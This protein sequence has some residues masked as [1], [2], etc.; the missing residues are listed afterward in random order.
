M[1]RWVLVTRPIGPTRLT[2]DVVTGQFY[3]NSANLPPG[4]KIMQI[5]ADG[6]TY[7]I[8][9]EISKRPVSQIGSLF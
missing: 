6:V 9:S 2:Y 7:K 3:S 8:N 4:T 5:L 1:D